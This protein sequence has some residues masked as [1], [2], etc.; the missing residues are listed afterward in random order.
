MTL[1]VGHPPPARRFRARRR[2][3]ER[4]PADRAVR[5]VG[6]G[7]DLAGQSDRRAARGRSEGRIVGRRPR[8]GR[9]AARIFVPKHKRRIGYVFQD[10]RLFPHLTVARICAYG[11]FFTPA[12]RA[13]RR[14]RRRGR[15][16][17]HRPPARPQAA[18]SVRR[19]K[20]ARGDRPRAD[21]Q[22]AA[23]PD[24]R[25]ARL[26]RRCAQGRDPALYRAAAR[27]DEDPDRLCQ[28][29]RRRGGAAGDRRGGAGR[30]QGRGE[31]RRPTD[32]LARLDLLARG[33]ARRGRRAGRA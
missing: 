2:L 7:Q 16:A 14:L 5:P 17:R 9:H 19:R 8:A 31:R 1:S 13:L 22:P 15:P 27:R 26:A 28:P 29:F 21:R 33:G 30:R 11:R 10:A 12:A 20:A 24:G 3:R 18:A 23:D 4:R 32:I 25:A 6:L